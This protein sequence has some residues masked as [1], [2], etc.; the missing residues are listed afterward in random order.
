MFSPSQEN[1]DEKAFLKPSNEDRIPVMHGI[2]LFISWML[3]L[4]AVAFLLLLL[5][6]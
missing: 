2:I 1:D 6:S 5:M 4:P 3:A